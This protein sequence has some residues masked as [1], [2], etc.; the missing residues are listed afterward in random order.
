[1]AESMNRIIVT[2]GAGFI[3]SAVVRLIVRKTEDSLCMAVAR[4][5]EIARDN[6]W[7]TPGEIRAGCRNMQKTNY[8]QYL[9]RLIE[10]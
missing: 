4:L 3:G 1:M 10:K 8:G 9:M 6:G 2:G 7:M 5:P